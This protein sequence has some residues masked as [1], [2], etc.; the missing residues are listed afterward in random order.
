MPAPHL[1]QNAA[2]SRIGTPQLEQNGIANHLPF[3]MNPIQT[4][5]KHHGL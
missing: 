2:P 5:T 4:G 1:L 3:S